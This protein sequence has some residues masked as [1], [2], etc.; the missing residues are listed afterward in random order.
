MP[1]L[2]NRL[3]ILNAT[4]KKLKKNAEGDAPT[5]EFVVPE[6]R[7]ICSSEDELNRKKT[8]YE[9]KIWTCRVTGRTSLTHKEATKSEHVATNTLKKSIED[10]YR[11]AFLGVVH[12]S[13]DLKSLYI[14]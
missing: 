4:A 2:G 14:S 8:L 13:K 9:S 11:T 12:K 7:E 10:H 6:T 1:L 3:H 5:H